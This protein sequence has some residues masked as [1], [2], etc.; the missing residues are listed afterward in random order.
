MYRVNNTRTTKKRQSKG[1]D[2][3]ERWKRWWKAGERVKFIGPFPNDEVK[4][5]L[6][7]TI[8]KN[9]GGMGYTVKFDGVEKLYVLNYHY[10]EL[11]H[12]VRG[13]SHNNI[14]K[15]ACRIKSEICGLHSRKQYRDTLINCYGFPSFDFCQ[16]FYPTMRDSSLEDRIIEL[17]TE[18]RE[19]VL[20]F[21]RWH[22]EPPEY[23]CLKTL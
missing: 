10:L 13:D 14:E 2:M 1:E 9:H 8:E 12:R 3:N 5:G 17:E 7:G 22:T 16:Q 23:I 6:E 18:F 11:V 20:P 21:K 19:K 4:I 15:T